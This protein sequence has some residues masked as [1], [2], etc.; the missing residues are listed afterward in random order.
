MTEADVAEIN[1]EELHQ[2]LKK[3]G[4]D[5]KARRLMGRLPDDGFRSFYEMESQRHHGDNGL[6]TLENLSLSPSVYYQTRR[7]GVKTVEGLKEILR[8]GYVPWGIGHYG[9][10]ELH[11][12]LRRWDKTANR[13]YSDKWPYLKTT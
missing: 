3:F 6:G 11:D 10:D 1:F 9:L 12:R 5:K 2:Y 7:F 4:R 13:S 8:D